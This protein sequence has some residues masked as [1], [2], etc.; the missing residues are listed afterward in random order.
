MKTASNKKRIIR[1]TETIIPVLVLTIAAVVVGISFAWHSAGSAASAQNIDFATKKTFVLN[2]NIGDTSRDNLPYM[3]QQAIGIDS[4]KNLSVSTDVDAPY[5]F[6]STIN[7]STQG[8]KKD[9]K[10]QLNSV[11]ISK[12]GHYLDIYNESGQYDKAFDTETVTAESSTKFH[13][14]ADIHLAFTWFFKAHTEDVSNKTLVDG[15]EKMKPLSPSSG[16]TWYT[17]FGTMVFGEGNKAQTLNGV[18][19]QALPS[20]AQDIADFVASD[21]ALFDLYIVFAPERVFWSQFFSGVKISA[22]SYKTEE[23]KEMLGAYFDESSPKYQMYYSDESYQ[24]SEFSFGATLSV[25]DRW[26]KEDV[27]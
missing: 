24:S 27:R 25:T 21:G 26:G 7:I 20:D 3:G 18:Q 17:P 1:A 19:A 9:L 2:F 15:N 10:L 16:E 12:G 8:E 6:V 5:Y 23:L 11:M 22:E 4:D 14:T 13:K